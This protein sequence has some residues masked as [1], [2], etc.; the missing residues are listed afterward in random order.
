MRA[1]GQLGAQRRGGAELLGA[2][3]LQVHPGAL[4]HGVE[5]A[6]GEGVA[7]PRAVAQGVPDHR[8]VL[9]GQATTPRG[10]PAQGP[11]LLGSAG[12]GIGLLRVGVGGLFRGLRV[13]ALGGVPARLLA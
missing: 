8:S 2:G 11:G 1:L 3:I 12:L 10:H 6:V 5:H 4:G 13:L 7:L 9:A